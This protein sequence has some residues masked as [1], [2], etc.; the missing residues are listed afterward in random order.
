MGLAIEALRWL[1]DM[2][3]MGDILDFDKSLSGTRGGR[4]RGRGRGR[5][6]GR[7]ESPR[8]YRSL[9]N[10]PVPGPLSV[11]LGGCETWGELWEKE[12]HDFLVSPNYRCFLHEHDSDAASRLLLT[13]TYS[14]RYDWKIPESY[15]QSGWG[16]DQYGIEG[17]LEDSRVIPFPWP[18]AIVHADETGKLKESVLPD[19]A[20]VQFAINDL[21]ANCGQCDLFISKCAVLMI[22]LPRGGRVEEERLLLKKYQRVVQKPDEDWDF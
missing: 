22:R 21:Y 14:L 6:G 16:D 11:V 2:G 15:D 9:L 12:G 13:P 20:E 8:G 4:G 5:G 1:S 3:M 10:T 18:A 7:A 17:A 19:L